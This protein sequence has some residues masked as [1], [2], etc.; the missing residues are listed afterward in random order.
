MWLKTLH[1][2]AFP[3]PVC[4]PACLPQQCFCSGAAT[5]LVARTAAARGQDPAAG[6]SGRDARSRPAPR[7]AQVPPL[8]AGE[9]PGDQEGERAL[10][11]SLPLLVCPAAA[12]PPPPPP[13]AGVAVAPPWGED[14]AAAGGGGRGP[15]GGPDAGEP[16]A[17]A[18]AGRGGGEEEEGG[19]G[20]LAA[21]AAAAG[22][23][24]GA[25]A[26]AHR[27]AP[28]C[29]LLGSRAPARSP[30]VRAL[31]DLS[32]ADMHACVTASTLAGCSAAHASAASALGGRAGCCARP[33]RTA[34][35]MRSWRRSST[36]RRR[37]ALRPPRPGTGRPPPPRR[38]PLP[39]PGRL[40]RRSRRGRRRYPRRRPRARAAALTP[41]P[42]RSRPPCCACCARAASR[43]AC[44]HT[45]AG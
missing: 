39:A 27:R 11:P 4:S 12:P 45:P 36:R 37:P 7:R 3:E 2:R 41:P 19:G 22:L 17:A 5:R 33:A 40:A 25:A 9:D 16:S 8:G 6:A 31:R 26:D 10:A 35:Q 23:P 21:H 44:P 15:P 32:G 14:A 34:F 24:A 42:P 30:H 18:H 28:L 1:D 38:R 29:T 20:G 13:A 43:A